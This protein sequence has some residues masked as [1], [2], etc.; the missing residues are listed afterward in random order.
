MSLFAAETVLLESG[1]VYEGEFTHYGSFEG[2]V[3]ASLGA[4]I[5]DAELY[6]Q[7][8]SQPTRNSYSCK[9]TEGNSCSGEGEVYIGVY[10]NESP[11]QNFW[12][13][14]IDFFR[15]RI[16]YNDELISKRRN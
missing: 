6:M 7:I 2:S 10:G 11:Y 12:P 5:G 14:L 9:V 16:S 13:L 3:T 1:S 4:V 8:G 15:G